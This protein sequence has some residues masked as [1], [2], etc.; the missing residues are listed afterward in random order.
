MNTREEV[1]TTIAAAG[2][3]AIAGPGAVVG[4]AAWGVARTAN[5]VQQDPG[6]R[7]AV[8]SVRLKVGHVI[9]GGTP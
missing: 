3:G 6:V 1:I 7:S 8:K 5:R 2:I 4:L 9:C